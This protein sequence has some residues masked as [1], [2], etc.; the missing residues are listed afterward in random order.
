MKTL[1]NI[2]FAHFTFSL[3]MASVYGLIWITEDGGTIDMDRFIIILKVMYCS[4]VASVSISIMVNQ[5]L[6]NN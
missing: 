4:I 6:K 2:A 1:K 5:Y 3:L